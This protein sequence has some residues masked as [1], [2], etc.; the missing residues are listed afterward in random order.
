MAT[1]SN[2]L[3]SLLSS[4]RENGA[5]SD[6]KIKC[7]PSIF[8][9]HCCIVRPQSRFFE[10]A[11]KGIFQEARSKEVTIVDDPLIVKKMIISIVR[12]M[13]TLPS[14]PSKNKSEAPRSKWVP[15]CMEGKI[16]ETK[17]LIGEHNDPTIS[18]WNTEQTKSHINATMYIVADKYAINGLM[19]LAKKN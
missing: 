11:M 10:N 16:L 1:G 6:L 8:I 18:T 4:I 2:F 13:T 7:G 15:P 14:S 5:F 3:L 12:T 19:D 9:V 17:V